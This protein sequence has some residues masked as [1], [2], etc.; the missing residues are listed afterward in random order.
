MT[1]L[2]A[3][4]LIDSGASGSV[5]RA[6]DTDAS[7]GPPFALKV[8][9]EASSAATEGFEKEA[10]YLSKLRHPGLVPI[11]GFS[12]TGEE[13]RGVDPAPCF[14]MELV[15]GQK[16]NEA[17]AN[18]PVETI[19][20]WLKQCLT[21]LDYLHSQGILHGDLKPAN[22]LIDQQSQV[23]LLDFGFAI[24]APMAGGKTL[25]KL[26]GALPYLAP[27]LV[28][29]ERYPATDLYALG[30]V[31]YEILAGRHP[32]KDA[33]NLQELFS[34]VFGRLADLSLPILP[35][36]ARVID[37]MI[38]SDLE[39][40][41][42]TAHNVL[43]ALEHGFK[44]TSISKSFHSFQLFGREEPWRQVLAFLKGRLTIK[45]PGLVLVHGLTG[46]GKTRF[47]QELFF[48]LILDGHKVDQAIPRSGKLLQPGVDNDVT[49]V[50][51]ASDLH[52]E[53]LKEFYRFLKQETAKPAVLI[54]EYND[55]LLAP[56]L[57][58][59]FGDFKKH[60][61]V[62]DVTL[63]PLD[64]ESTKRFL[65]AVLKKDLPEEVMLEVFERTQG[66]PEL[67]TQMAK[68][69]V[70]RGLVTKK[71]IA[72]KDLREISLSG[73]F[74]DLFRARLHKLSSFERQIIQWLATTV[75]PLPRHHLAAVSQRESLD[76][77]TALNHLIEQG[78][79]KVVS[80]D[81]ES[82]R[83]AHPALTALALEPLSVKK[84]QAMH[85]RWID[86]W[87]K[88]SEE[89]SIEAEVLFDLAHHVSSIPSHPK[90]LE[91]LT[92]VG[93][94]YR[95]RGECDQAVQL[96]ER[97]LK[98]ELGCEEREAFLRQLA[99][100]Y[101]GL[102]DFRENIRVIETW[103]QE[104]PEDP[105]GINPLKFGL[106]TGVAYKNL[107]DLE[108]ARRRFNHCLDAGNP[109]DPHHTLRLARAHSLLGLLDMASDNF[110]SAMA[111][112]NEAHALLPE[113]TEQKAEI[114]K[115]QASWAVHQKDWDQA[116]IYLT[117]AEGIY[118]AL[119]SPRGLFAVAL[120]KGNLALQ[121]GRLGDIE[122]AY[123]EA[124]EIA[125]RSHDEALLA[126]VYQNLGVL[127]CRRGDY[128]HALE[129]LGKARELFLFFGSAYE[130]GLNLLQLALASA[131]VGYFVEAD[132]LLMNFRDLD[133]SQNFLQRL[134]EIDFMIET[135]KIGAA[136]T[137]RSMP[138]SFGSEKET[139]DW[140]LEQRWLYLMLRRDAVDPRE[141][142]V[143]LQGMY[144]PLSDP[145]KLSFEE[146]PD[147]RECFNDK[148]VSVQGESHAMDVLNKLN[149]ITKNLLSSSDVDEVLQRIMTAAMELSRAERG[150]LLVAA[151]DQS[152]PIEGFAVK[153]AQN[154]SKELLASEDFRVSLTA[155]QEVV[156]SGE[157][158]V[159]D[160][161]ILDQRFETAESVHDL[162]LKSILVL[163]LKEDGAVD[164]V[165][166][167]D[168]RYETEIFR[169][170][171]L[172]ILQMFA[173]H[174][175]LA[176]QKAQ[177]ITQ[178]QNSNRQ[179]N[180]TVTTQKSEL[181]LLRREVAEQRQKL[182]YEYGEII[183][184][185]RA[186]LEVL[187]LVDRLIDTSI[188]VWIYG[189]SGTGKEM[190]A[191]AL[192]YKGSRAKKPF[193]S[194]N[195]SSLPE[196]LLESELFGHKK[197]SFTHADR[198]KI[199][200]LQHADEGTVFLDEISDMSPAMQAKLLRFLQEG[201]IRPIGSNRV[202]K[203][204][205]RVVSASNWDLNALIGEGKFREDL[206]YRLNGMTVSLPPLRGRVEDVPLLVQHFLKKLARDEKR[207][208][209][210]ISPE[211]LELLAAY[212]WPGNV[213][214]LENTIRSASLFHYKKKLLPKSFHFKKVLF[215]DGV[216]AIMGQGTVERPKE[217][218]SEKNLILKALHSNAYNK[219]LAAEALGI[220]RRYLYTQ[221]ARYDIPL[222]RVAMKAYVEREL[223]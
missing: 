43:E 82:Y 188:P 121:L 138:P 47:V 95:F 88:M 200:L 222:K 71:H 98:L 176:L 219:K 143:V 10:Y 53:H 147:Y 223:S 112:F 126:R 102:G 215:G 50:R 208:P 103:Y 130:Q 69:M 220:S 96:F 111:H 110:S 24:F 128:I 153:V 79:V 156:K 162:E 124:L 148:T 86:Y 56:A 157:P 180:D 178:L 108:E 137:S 42:K 182:T 194:E 160:N 13:L 204:D 81:E 129:E 136:P 107:G 217:K 144:E 184:Q 207:E 106:S 142:R 23:R 73:D 167:L 91:W 201:E 29:G 2:Q 168:H 165:L 190:I 161:A 117:L 16:I 195:C 20:D 22:I 80:A 127:A 60:S 163:P 206:F 1:Q 11:Y 171:D 213:R 212:D 175:S 145:L 187:S 100:A 113:E 32:R 58:H 192:H 49:I 159:T 41:F 141:L 37:R 18:V 211:A 26:K 17:A 78:L 83:L 109:E 202:I 133:A 64:L 105:L 214:E 139:P 193:V 39:R 132:E 166:Y 21:A 155:V 97:C 158:L 122:A 191:K 75:L 4:E 146:R 119:A 89:E 114:Y 164:G 85:R 198:D 205:V 177:M 150:F 152:S 35:R 57:E 116:I 199:G 36:L 172:E 34:P 52:P 46:I 8:L 173:D 104:F 90:R 67:L 154:I 51:S 216:P 66:N 74:Q 196:T 40:R 30:T 15:E 54:L 27:E 151:D 65:G 72:M 120:E 183:G 94:T 125:A 92:Q 134:E 221:L 7:K 197:G 185:S 179:L 131:S 5:Y 76:V 19:R 61:Q 218:M 135:L 14:W 210:E 169:G 31:F 84:I 59:F 48:Q 170:A 55:D 45:K 12:K 181:T 115:H 149:A 28:K 174:A 33:R 189:E 63:G 118:Q 6:H 140:D 62:L 99:N 77:G 44:P 38:E 87:E 209:Y 70:A 68:E 25:G 9:K 3:D 186:M 203:V 93:E 101:G 123:G